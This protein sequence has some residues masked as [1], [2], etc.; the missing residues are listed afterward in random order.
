MTNGLKGKQRRF[1]EEYLIDL[2]ATKAY[3]RAGY[4]EKG[5]QQAAFKLLSNAVI[6]EVLGEAQ[7]ERSERAEITQDWVIERLKVIAN[8]DIEKIAGSKKDAWAR[9]P[10]KIA[11]LNLLGK[12]LDMFTDKVEHSGQIAQPVINLTVNGDVEDVLPPPKLKLIGN[13]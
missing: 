10:D 12:H 8:L 5:A 4:S 3:I 2:N 13:G 1:V 7:K 11:A 9:M 6:A